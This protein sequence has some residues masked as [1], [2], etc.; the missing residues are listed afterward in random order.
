MV[1]QS[2]ASLPESMSTFMVTPTTHTL[3]HV[4]PCT[5]VLTH[6]HTLILTES[7][8]VLQPPGGRKREWLRL[9]HESNLAGW[10]KRL[11]QKGESLTGIFL[12]PWE[13]S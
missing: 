3:V 8:E 2:L 4:D 11:K 9:G 13:S 12:V 7:P 10:G 5:F 1:E 6:T